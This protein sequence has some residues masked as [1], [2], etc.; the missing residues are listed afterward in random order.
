MPGYSSVLRT[1]SGVQ[2]LLWGTLPEFNPSPTSVFLYECAV[3]LHDNPNV[4]LEFTLDR[5][6]VYISNH[7]DKAAVV[8]VRFRKEVWDLILQEP[9][10]EI[11][12]ELFSRYTDT[13]NYLDGEEPLTV[14]SLFVAKGAAGLKRDNYQE[15]PNLQAPPGPAFVP[16][17][18][19]GAP[20]D[21]GLPIPKDSQII[22][23][24]GKE[25]ATPESAKLVGEFVP[26]LKAVSD[27]TA[28]EKKSFDLM[29]L[30]GLNVKG[31]N[32]PQQKALCVYCLGA[33][34]AVPALIDLMGSEADNAGP[35]REAAVQ[36]IRRWLSRGPQ[37]CNLLYNAKTEKG[38][39]VDKGFKPVEAEAMI[40]LLFFEY[41]EA[42]RNQRATYE[43][44]AGFLRHSKMAIRELAFHHLRA[45][46]WG[47]KGLPDY[48]PSW[49]ATR[50][51]KAASDW[52]DLI[53]K[54]ML[55]PH[56]PPMTPPK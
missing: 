11:V 31:A 47:M 4:D 18:N 17:S 53:M 37:T 9:D 26:S 21:K 52:E 2:L 27:V 42:S 8:R 56:A 51:N 20:P 16:W 13:I 54:G 15:I 36:A 23:F 10:T 43:T 5:G 39:L 38:L 28:G 1:D 44:F 29:L 32:W 34:D 40:Q 30:E 12:L 22:I 25:P 55:P 3:T 6:R 14:L 50:R 33:I 7:K 46:T 49:D 19:K 35:E 41:T 24:M 48:D 45:M